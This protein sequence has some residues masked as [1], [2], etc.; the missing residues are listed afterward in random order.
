VIAANALRRRKGSADGPLRALAPPSPSRLPDEVFEK[1]TPSGEQ[2]NDCDENDQVCAGRRVTSSWNLRDSGGSGISNGR[3][4]KR[5]TSTASRLGAA[6]T[7]QDALATHLTASARSAAA[8]RSS[9]LET[10][11]AKRAIR[12]GRR[13]TARRP[14][15][16]KGGSSAQAP[17]VPRKSAPLHR[18]RPRG[19]GEGLRE[20]PGR[21]AP[22]SSTAMEN[23]SATAAITTRR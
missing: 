12:K 2:E 17:A 5:S 9:A 15:A 13:V 7:S 10:S 4:V 11:S 14:A 22:C 6:V 19:A 20:N 18:R 1:K 23:R 3:S 8:S 21:T 16:T